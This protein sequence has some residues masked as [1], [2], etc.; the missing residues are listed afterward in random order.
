MDTK[1]K[2]KVDKDEG[3]DVK[4]EL[5]LVDDD[6]GDETVPKTDSETEKE[7][8]KSEQVLSNMI[9]IS[10]NQET[11]TILKNYAK[12][13]GR[14]VPIMVQQIVEEWAI[15]QKKGKSRGMTDEQRLDDIDEKLN[16]METVYKTS[17][18]QARRRVRELKERNKEKDI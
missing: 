15:K 9:V 13:I 8:K 1:K 11:N 5:K 6:N 4:S 7:Y 12:K 3:G 2:G 10:P 18:S 14:Q 16:S 17:I